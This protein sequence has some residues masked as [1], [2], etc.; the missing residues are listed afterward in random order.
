MIGL[1]SVNLFCKGLNVMDVNLYVEVPHCSF[2]TS[3]NVKKYKQ[4]TPLDFVF[5][6]YDSFSAVFHTS[7]VGSCGVEP[8]TQPSIQFLSCI[9]TE[10]PKY[11]NHTH[12][13][14]GLYCFA[15]STHKKVEEQRSAL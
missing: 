12:T 3:G 10:K 7:V 6:K 4:D 14:H 15:T 11:Y 5:P 1:V 2:N 8:V 13:L 9:H